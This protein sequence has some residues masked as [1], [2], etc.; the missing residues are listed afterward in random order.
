MGSERPLALTTPAETLFSSPNG[1]PDRQ[2]PFACPQIARAAQLHHRQVLGRNPQHSHV[3]LRVRAQH[4]GH[5][6]A[7][8]DQLHCDIAGVAHHLGV[9]QDQPFGTDDEARALASRGLT[10]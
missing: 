8:I 9:G 6:F 1:E 4:L 5:E 7:P 3:G 2:H 10:G